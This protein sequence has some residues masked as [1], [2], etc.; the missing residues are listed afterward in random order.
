MI[1]VPEAPALERF[2][3]SDR[4]A[5]FMAAVMLHSGYFMRRQVTKHRGK[6]AE[7]LIDKVLRNEHA[8]EE[9]Y[10]S[11]RG[12]GTS[13]YHITFKP[14]YAALGQE[15]NR[16]R[17]NRETLRV[18]AKLMGLDYVLLHP[19]FRYLPT[20]QQKV[21]YFTHNRGMSLDVL[22]SRLY[23]SD[24]SGEMRE[25][26]RYFVDKFPIQVDQETNRIRFCFL[27]A[28]IFSDIVFQT[29]LDQYA[30][31]AS[32]LGNAE[33]VYVSNTSVHMAKAERRFN[34]IFGDQPILQKTVLDYFQHRYAIE[35]TGGKDNTVQEL[36]AFKELR[37]KHADQEERYRQWLNPPPASPAAAAVS[38]STYLIP[39]TYSFIGT[40]GRE[41]KA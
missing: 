23:V 21:E 13:V 14:L 25:T 31:L 27:D 10:I 6:G 11:G 20:E 2:G 41:A 4:Q 7:R 17:R 15:D 29:W 33:V 40:M 39:H 12:T 30:P 19:S 28:G 1:Q 5:N 34:A 24:L 18:R 8:T 22:P 9:R 37:K 3:Y 16:N 35:S 32:A 36:L 38:F 26:T